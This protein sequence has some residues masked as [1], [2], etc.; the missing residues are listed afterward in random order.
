MRTLEGIVFV[1]EIDPTCGGCVR[2]AN[3]DGGVTAAIRVDKSFDWPCFSPVKA[4]PD[5]DSLAIG[6][7][8]IEIAKNQDVLIV[9]GYSG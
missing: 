6:S 9:G 4:H 3:R 8:R 2:L 7:L 5:R 1:V